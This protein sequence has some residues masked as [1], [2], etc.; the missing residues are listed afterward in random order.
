MNAISC[1]SGFSLIEVVVAILILG[2]ALVGLTEGVTAAL[3]SSKASERQTMAAQLAAGQIETL[4][5]GGSY[6]DGQTT[7]DFGDEFSQYRWTQTISSEDIPGLYDVEVEVEDSQTGS[8]IYDLKT[9]LF[10]LPQG[11]NSVASSAGGER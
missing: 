10:E 3:G 6:D 4:R 9:S 1:Q 2:I 11:S 7:G 8:A 5:A